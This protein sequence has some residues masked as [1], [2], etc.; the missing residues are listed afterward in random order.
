M[1]QSVAD[2]LLELAQ[3]SYTRCQETP[4]FFRAFYDRFLQS[5]PEIPPYFAHTRFDRQHRLLLH[6]ISL[7]LIYARRP[8]PHLLQRIVERHGPD[9]LNIPARLYPHFVDSFLLTVRDHDPQY[10]PSVEAAWRAA[11]A[12]GIAFMTESAS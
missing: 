8:N 10:D 3:G 11:L 6:G 12:P 5:S 2:H 9:D 4:D 1:T 7:L